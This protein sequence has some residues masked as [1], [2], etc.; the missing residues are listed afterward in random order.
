MTLLSCTA[1]AQSSVTLYGLL[2]VTMRYTTNQTT[3]GKSN[4]RM[5]DGPLTGSRWGIRGVEDLGGGTKI[6]LVLESGYFL[7]NGHSLQGRRLFGRSS[8]VGIQGT[9]GTLTLGRQ[10]TTMHEMIPTYDAMG[11]SNYAVVGFQGGNYTGDRQDN[12]VKYTFT[13]GGVTLKTQHSFGN[14]AGSFS[15]NATDG[16]SLA[17]AKDG[18]QVGGAYQVIHDLTRFYDLTVPSSL[19]RIWSVGGSYAIPSGTLFLGYTHSWIDNAD[20]RNQAVNVG[21]KYFITPFTQFITAITGDHLQHAGTSGNR[22]TSAVMLDYNLSK[23]TDIYVE[24][25]Y[26]RLGGAWVTFAAQPS[27]VTPFYGKNNQFSF[28]LGLRHRF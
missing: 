14:V 1:L 26:S 7:P 12:M 17:Y 16:I 27:F 28:S 18:W 21:V 23:A 3:D 4:L 6:L 8:Y 25:D 2:D 10:Y 22:L 9:A 20:Y 24:A 11:L 13:Y 19:Q 15:R 5:A